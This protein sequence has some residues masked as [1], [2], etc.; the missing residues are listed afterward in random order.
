MVYT[1]AQQLELVNKDG[2]NIHMFDNPSTAVQVAAA[3]EDGTEHSLITNP[4]Q[5]AQLAIFNAKFLPTL[6]QEMN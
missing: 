4:C 2:L 6:M 5:Q 1:E 3:R